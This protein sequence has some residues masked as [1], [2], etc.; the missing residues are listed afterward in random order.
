L[1]LS[2]RELGDLPCPRIVNDLGA[3]ELGLVRPGDVG[4]GTKDDGLG[5]LK[6]R[7]CGWLGFGRLVGAE[8]PRS[9]FGTLG[10]AEA[11]AGLREGAGRLGI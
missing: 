2:L 11:R 3:G 8:K 4:F 5:D 1:N 6:L 9:S 7:T 10:G